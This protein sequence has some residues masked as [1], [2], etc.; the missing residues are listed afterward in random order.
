MGFFGLK[1][2]FNHNQQTKF[3]KKV[4]CPFTQAS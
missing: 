4:T 3:Q 1:T 2:D